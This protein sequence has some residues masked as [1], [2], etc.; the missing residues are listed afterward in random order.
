[1]HSRLAQFEN[2]KGITMSQELYW[3]VLTALMT[4]LFW[5][6]YVLNRF[7]EIGIISA[8]FG[9]DAPPT[10]QAGWA[11]RMT[12]AHTN[13]VENLAV[14]VPLVLAV[15]L[16]GASSALTVSACMVYFY[17]RLAH[18]I[19][20]TLGIPALRTVAFLIGFACQLILALAFL[21]ML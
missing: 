10:A 13:A 9:S 14:F 15:H 11:Q 6:P 19:V 3:M 20:Y 1:M 16:S 18:F 2:R 21:G 7:A 8:V 17:A 5:V 12:K 4:G